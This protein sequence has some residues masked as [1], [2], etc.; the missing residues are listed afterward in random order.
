[1]PWH[2]EI[3]SV[4]SMQPKTKSKRAIAFLCCLATLMATRRWRATIATWNVATLMRP[5]RAEQIS[6]QL[7]KVP[8]LCVQGTRVRQ[9]E[10]LPHTGTR[11]EHHMA[12]HAGYGCSPLTN[13]H[14]GVA[15][16][17]ANQ[18]FQPK[19]LKRITV[20][21]QALQGRGLSVTIAKGLFRVRCVSAYLPPCPWKKDSR[22]A[23]KK[24]CL[25]LSKWIRREIETT[26]TNTTPVVCLDGN[27]GVLPT[28][29]LQIA[30]P[31]AQTQ[32]NYAGDLLAKIAA[33]LEMAFVDSF[34]PTGPTFENNRTAGSHPDHIMVPQAFLGRVSNVNVWR[35]ACWHLRAFVKV[36]DHYPLAM[37][38]DLAPPA[39]ATTSPHHNWDFDRL[40]QTLQTGKDRVPFLAALENKL[41]QHAPLFKIFEKDAEPTRE[42]SLLIQCGREVAADF[43]KAAPPN[44]WYK[45]VSL[46]RKALLAQRASYMILRLPVP[47]QIVLNLE[48]STKA[49]RRVRLKERYETQAKLDHAVAFS[50]ARRRFADVH[51]YA[52]LRAGKQLGI[53]KRDYRAFGS[54]LPDIDEVEA[55]VSRQGDDSG[56]AARRAS[57]HSV[58]LPDA[59]PLTDLNP[60][61]TAPIEPF[62]R[63]PPTREDF[64]QAAKDMLYLAHGLKNAPRRKYSPAW[65]LPSEI[66]CLLVSPT[67]LSKPERRVRAI[68]VDP[69]EKELDDFTSEAFKKKRRCLE[70]ARPFRKARQR[71]LRV[72]AAVRAS[73]RLPATA[74]CSQVFLT[75]KRKNIEGCKGLRWLH[76][77]CAWWRIFFK[78]ALLHNGFA[79]DAPHYA[80]GGIRA[81]RREELM[82]ISRCLAHRLRVANVSFLTKSYDMQSA[83]HSGTLTDLA[84]KKR[85]SDSQT[86]PAT[87]ASRATSPSSRP[88]A[89]K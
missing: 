86:P 29:P 75:D 31:F 37:L 84:E 61:T 69:F 33:D 40:A 49:L 17:L 67:W 55:F 9:T 53:K 28:A 56:F 20:P 60:E 19:H 38:C 71:M 18:R 15:I 26:P 88:A 30:G 76:T 85:E 43:F 72:H 83:F 74:N 81:R 46:D 32:Q 12:I 52:R 41:D 4:F 6:E 35:Q 79:F 82:T 59:P 39:L 78:Q 5:Y 8:I 64:Q 87:N 63:K 22:P 16:F 66:F 77:F 42:A 58:L 57:P 25:D 54:F 68:G 51:K 62:A 1:M 89:S 2:R 34:Y 21:P 11:M 48:A 47:E 13:N 80:F 14:A 10:N 3:F 50:Y 23:W 65:S 73:G 7:K 36:P 24:A 27:F 44:Q 45:T 70:E